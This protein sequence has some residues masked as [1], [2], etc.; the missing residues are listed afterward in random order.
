MMYSYYKDLRV[1]IR[2]DKWTTSPV[3]IKK[4]VFE[5]DPWAL[6]AFNITWNIAIDRVKKCPVEGYNQ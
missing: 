4:G 3:S 6:V 2:T 1:Q 5:G